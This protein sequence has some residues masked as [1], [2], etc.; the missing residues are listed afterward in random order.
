MQKIPLNLAAPSMVLAK[1]VQREDGMVLLAEGTELSDAL[2]A[3][4]K[5]MRVEHIVVEGTPVD[6]EGL[7]FTPTKTP[8]DLDRLFRKHTDNPFMMKLKSHLA[9]YFRQRAALRA[10]GNGGDDAGEAAP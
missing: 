1:P 4:L 8:E 9:E 2:I 6:L 5:S 3:R 10:A 7:S